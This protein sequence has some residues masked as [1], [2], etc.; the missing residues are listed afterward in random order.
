MIRIIILLSAAVLLVS[1]Q[2]PKKKYSICTFSAKHGWG[3]KKGEWIVKE[4]K[5]ADETGLVPVVK[6]IKDVLRETDKIRVMIAEAEGNCFATIANGQRLLVID[7]D[8]LEN[9]NR[10]AD[11]EW[12]AISIIA[13]EIGHHVAG[14]SGTSHEN[15]LAADYWSGY[16]LKKLGAGESAT[17]KAMEH[18]G[19]EADSESHPNKYSRIESIRKGYEDAK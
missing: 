10:T 4:A 5:D 8:F 16:A 19:S 17:I 12:A 9:V 3:A 18:F 2:S 7:V 13:H 6:Q 1:A 11:T 15:E 14:F